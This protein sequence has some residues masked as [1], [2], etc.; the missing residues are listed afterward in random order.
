DAVA[1]RPPALGVMVAPDTGIAVG[2][3]L[4]RHRQ[5]ILLIRTRRLSSPHLRVGAHKRLHVM[6]EL[7]GDD[8]GAR[9]ITRRPETALQLAEEPQIE[10]DL[11]IRGAVEGAGRGLREPAAGLVGVAE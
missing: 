11:V 9:E 5:R 7:V 2:L 4:E 1:A 6:S 8:V 3:E 10:V